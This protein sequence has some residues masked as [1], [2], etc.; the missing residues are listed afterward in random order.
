[1]RS[2]IHHEGS[3]I[4]KEHEEENVLYQPVFFVRLDVFV[5]EAAARADHS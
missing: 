4:T 3:K 1:M 5:V 2:Y